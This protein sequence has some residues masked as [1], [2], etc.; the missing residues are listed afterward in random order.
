M[1]REYF[2]KVY[3]LNLCLLCGLILLLSVGGGEE[4]PN[5]HRLGWD[6]TSSDLQEVPLPKNLVLAL[7]FF[8][9]YV[10]GY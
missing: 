7:M 5:P 8:E 9:A 1:T 10:S 2:I 3:T 6:P 4:Q